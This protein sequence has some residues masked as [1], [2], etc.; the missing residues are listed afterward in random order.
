[1]LFSHKSAETEEG[2]RPS[3]PFAPHI[4]GQPPG[5]P[6]RPLLHHAQTH[7]NC[8]FEDPDY[9]RVDTPFAEAFFLLFP[10][11]RYPSPLSS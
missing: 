9:S 5:A 10:L 11:F 4:V 3:S 7:E 8:F 2:G 1:M 6:Y